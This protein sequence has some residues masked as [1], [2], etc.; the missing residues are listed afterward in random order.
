MA[1]PYNEDEHRFDKFDFNDWGESI[2][3]VSMEEAQVLAIQHARDNK[4]FY[5][6]KFSNRDITWDV[7]DVEEGEDYYYIR[8]SY[9][10]LA[11]TTDSPG[12]EL[13]TVGKTG[14]IEMRQIIE[15]PMAA[16]GS[17]LFGSQIAFTI[18]TLRNS[19]K[20]FAHSQNI[21]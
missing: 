20:S 11:N 1:G 19:V 6:S 21:Q 15:E 4:H 9:R 10:L 7:V 18:Q 3:H 12:I 2:E 14:T 16:A 8:I 17:R 13:F 5:G